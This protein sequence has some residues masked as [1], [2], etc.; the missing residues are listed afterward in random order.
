MSTVTLSQ[1]LAQLTRPHMYSAFRFEKIESARSLRGVRFD[2]SNHRLSLTD[3]TAM[4]IGK[5]AKA[6]NLPENL[7]QDFSHVVV[8]DWKMKDPQRAMKKH[9]IHVVRQGFGEEEVASGK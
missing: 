4:G 3:S 7:L 9:F 6:L 2:I 1:L 5:F 8:K